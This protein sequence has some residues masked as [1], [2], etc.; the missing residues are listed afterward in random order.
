M[1]SK[2]KSEHQPDRTPANDEDVVVGQSLNG[3]IVDGHFQFRRLDLDQELE[4]Y[5]L[6]S[7]YYGHV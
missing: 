5:R 7:R 1:A 2:Y 4:K 3:H 6:H